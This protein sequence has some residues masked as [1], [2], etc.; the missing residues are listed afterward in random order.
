MSDQYGLTFSNFNV[1]SA[2][3]I[4]TMALSSVSNTCTCTS[5]WRWSSLPAISAE[6]AKEIDS[7]VDYG[8]KEFILFPSSIKG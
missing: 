1:S 7:G 3:H 8:E 4:H 2:W 6:V 5:G